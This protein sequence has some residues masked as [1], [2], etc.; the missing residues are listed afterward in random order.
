MKC[1]GL[2]RGF[3][4]FGISVFTMHD[5][6]IPPAP[7][8]KYAPGFM[9]G[10]AFMGHPP[11]IYVSH[12]VAHK[13]HFDGGPAVQQGHDAGYLIPHIPVVTSVP[14]LMLLVHMAVSKHKVMFPAMNVL[15]DGKPMG[16]YFGF[17][18][19]AIC[20]NPVS[21]PTGVLIKLSGTVVHDMTLTDFLWGLA[22][23]VVDTVIDIL[24]SKIMKGENW[25]GAASLLD[26]ARIPSALIRK[27]SYLWRIS[28]KLQDRIP[29]LRNLAQKLS[30]NVVKKNTPWYKR[31]LEKIFTDKVPD[32]ANPGQFLAAG[33][34]LPLSAKLPLLGSHVLSKWTDHAAKSWVVSP[35]TSGLIFQAAAWA[36]GTPSTSVSSIAFG[37]AGLHV[38]FFTSKGIVSVHQ[39]VN[40]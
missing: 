26:K 33:V 3:S 1:Y 5:V 24:W 13:V 38:S 14:N 28:G 36:T 18:L 9:E 15:V 21:L 10:P 16:M 27:A 4:Q 34:K 17:F 39:N 6:W 20:S 35:F 30:A 2:H 12:K 37:R 29:A 19:G 25:R 7:I 40:N 31:Q 11:G 32:P 8:V 23:L 22:M